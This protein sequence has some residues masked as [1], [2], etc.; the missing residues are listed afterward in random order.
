MQLVLRESA[1]D[2]PKPFTLD[3]GLIIFIVGH[4]LSCLKH[5]QTWIAHRRSKYGAVPFLSHEQQSEV[6]RQY[7]RCLC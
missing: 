6:S 5:L 3:P 7:S 2:D 1:T 4:R